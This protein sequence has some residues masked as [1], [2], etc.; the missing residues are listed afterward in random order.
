MANQPSRFKK[1]LSIKSGRNKVILFVALLV[2]AGLG[3]GWL[4]VKALSVIDSYNNTTLVAATWN[5]TV[6]TS[7]G[8]VKLAT[9]SC[10]IFSWYCSASTTCANTLGDGSYIIVAQADAST[11]KQWKTA[12]TSCDKPQCGADGGQDGD[13]L[14]AD[15]TTDFTSYPAR[16]YC[17]SI[18]ARL[19]TNSELGCMYTNRATF[20]NNFGAGSYWSETEL[21]ATYARYVSFPDG[22]Q[23]YAFKTNT[24]YVRCV[25]GW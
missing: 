16:D 11:T 15:N 13:N 5:L 4:Y 21:S 3:A 20:G 6:A 19:P 24:Y 1:F 23:Y 17:K 10:D 2:V 8:E 22:D 18:G 14:V 9:K 25:K 7:S 12:N